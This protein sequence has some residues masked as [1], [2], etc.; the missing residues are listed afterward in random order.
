MSLDQLALED[1]LWIIPASTTKTGRTYKVP[2][3]MAAVG[4]IQAQVLDLEQAEQRRSRSARREARP[5]TNLFPNKRTG[6]GP[7]GRTFTNRPHRAACKRAGIV[8]YKPHD[9]RHSFATHMEQMGIPRLTWD[10]LLGHSANGMADLY[11]GFDFAE[12]RLDAMERWADRIAAALGDNV[13]S[14]D[15]SRDKPA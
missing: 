14:M 11:S 3:S 4:I 12:Q 7:S 13:V 15:R 1:R 8:G 2:L 10:A 9:H 5:V 6:Q